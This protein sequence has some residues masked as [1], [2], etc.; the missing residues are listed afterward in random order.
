[1][2]NLDEQNALRERYR[3]S[4]PEWRPATDLYAELARKAILPDSRLLDLGCGRGG[5]VEQL[6]HPRSL[7]VGA[8]PDIRSLREHRLAADMDPLPRVG[9]PTECLP[10]SRSTFDIVIASWL[11][12]HLSDPATSFREIGRVLKK[13]GVFLFLTPNRRHPLVNLNRMVGRISGIQG[14][15]VG[16][17]YGRERV[18]TFPAYYRANTS[19]ALERLAGTGGMRL[20]T[21]E[22]VADPT[23]FALRA[24]L[25]GLATRI[26]SSLAS[27]RHIHLV[28]QMV[29]E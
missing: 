9:A 10:F 12:E 25:F 21:L 22:T 20:S 8:D 17:L 6:E 14:A 11:L 26:D 28:G 3:E 19:R 23:Y 13:G 16:Q 1:M 27:D 15:V 4:N 2:L 7:M 24:G 29:R 18:D 5:L